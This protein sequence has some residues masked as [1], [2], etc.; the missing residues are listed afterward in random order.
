MLKNIPTCSAV[1]ACV[2]VLPPLP[3]LQDR[4]AQAHLI[5]PAGSQPHLNTYGLMFTMLWWNEWEWPRVTCHTDRLSIYHIGA[6][7]GLGASKQILMPAVPAT[8]Y[9]LH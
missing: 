2:L 4:S 1:Q 8:E 6:A 5:S 9:V 7:M 3:S